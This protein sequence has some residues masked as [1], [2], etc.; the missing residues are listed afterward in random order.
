MARRQLEEEYPE[1]PHPNPSLLR[2]HQFHYR[3]GMDNENDPER[4]KYHNWCITRDR[5]ITVIALH[6]AKDPTR[7][8]NKEDLTTAEQVKVELI[9]RHY[10]YHKHLSLLTP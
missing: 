10:H 2:P 3:M 8:S 1:A 6:I 5:Q 9:Q 4:K 7:A